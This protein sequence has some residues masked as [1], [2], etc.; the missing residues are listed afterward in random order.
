[1]AR[2]ANPRA[3]N[4]AHPASRPALHTIVAAF[5]NPGFEGRF[6]DARLFHLILFFLSNATRPEL[7]H[8]VEY[9]KSETPIVRARLPEKMVT[10][11]ARRQLVKAG[12]ILGKAIHRLVSSATPITF[13]FWR[14]ADTEPKPNT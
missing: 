10:T 3:D 9:L 12:R 6:V 14:S 4:L 7:G 11:E 1:M 2:D 13:V 8:Q 5:R